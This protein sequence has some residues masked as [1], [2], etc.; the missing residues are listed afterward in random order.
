VQ[1]RMARQGA[2]QGARVKT[3]WGGWWNSEA[4]EFEQCVSKFK[5]TTVWRCGADTV[6]VW[7]N[8]ILL[9]CGADTLIV[10]ILLLCIIVSPV[11]LWRVFRACEESHGRHSQI[12]KQVPRELAY[13]I[14]RSTRR[15]HQVQPSPK[16]ARE[17]RF[18]EQSV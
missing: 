1:E 8:T 17:E 10:L 18:R 12:N 14:S 6:I 3:L 11:V 5:S 15:V 16:R 4:A 7:I 2:R 13:L 9:L